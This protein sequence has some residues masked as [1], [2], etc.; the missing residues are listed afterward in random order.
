MIEYNNPPTKFHIRF[1]N[2]LSFW[3]FGKIRYKI[4]MEIE[5]INKKTND[6]NSVLI[7]FVTAFDDSDAE[8]KTLCYIF[9]SRNFIKQTR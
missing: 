1:F 4:K 7:D 3:I 6:I 5:T 2:I 8:F 9:E